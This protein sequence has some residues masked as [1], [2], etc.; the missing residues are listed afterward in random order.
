[1]RRRCKKCKSRLSKDRYSMFGD[2]CR[3]CSKDI[4]RQKGASLRPGYFGGSTV[5]IDDSVTSRPG[6]FD[7]GFN[8]Y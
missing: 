4:A 3:K 1:M 7:C 8:P 6:T 2:Y 5:K